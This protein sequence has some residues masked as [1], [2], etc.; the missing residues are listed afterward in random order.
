[1]DADQVLSRY[2]QADLKRICLRTNLT[3]AKCLMAECITIT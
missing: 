1:M 3:G 2:A